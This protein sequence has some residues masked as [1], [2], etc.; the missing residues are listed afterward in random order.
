MV[1][2][3]YYNCLKYAF[4]GEICFE[5]KRISCVNKYMQFACLLWIS[6]NL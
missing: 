4:S 2:Y 5:M 1:D 6:T 3:K